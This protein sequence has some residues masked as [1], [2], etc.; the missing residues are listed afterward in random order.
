MPARLQLLAQFG[1]VINFSV[2]YD[3]GSFIFVADRLMSPGEI[4]DA[5]PPHAQADRA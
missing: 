4:D 3:P 5:Q 2:E 1:V